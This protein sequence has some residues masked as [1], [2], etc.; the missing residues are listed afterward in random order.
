MNLKHYKRNWLNRKDGTAFVESSSDLEEFRGEWNFSATLCIAD[1]NRNINLEF[2]ASTVEDLD[3]RL[4]KL[5]MLRK[6]L[7][8]MDE[9]MARAREKLPTREEAKAAAAARKREQESRPEK[10]NVNVVRLE[11][12]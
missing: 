9:K 8:L 6:H 7:D 10:V 12:L 11:D 2:Y 1:C 4:E 5:D 3:D